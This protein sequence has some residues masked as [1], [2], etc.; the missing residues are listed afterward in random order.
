MNSVSTQNFDTQ[1]IKSSSII[2]DDGEIYGLIKRASRLRGF[3]TLCELAG[4]LQLF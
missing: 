4:D 3:P 1:R 2:L